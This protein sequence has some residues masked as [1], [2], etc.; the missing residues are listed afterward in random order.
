MRKKAT[1]I[2][3]VVPGELTGGF[4]PGHVALFEINLPVALLDLIL[5]SD[6][7]LRATFPG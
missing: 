5:L 2:R 4:G 1:K 6:H 7:S 3:I